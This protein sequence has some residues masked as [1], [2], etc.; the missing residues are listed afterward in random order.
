MKKR[1][2]IFVLATL[3]ALSIFAQSSEKPIDPKT[4]QVYKVQAAVVDG[5]TIPYFGLSEVTIFANGSFD[6][7]QLDYLT[8]CV[9]K[10]YPYAKITSETLAEMDVEMTKIRSK[11]DRK[12]YL[13]WAEDELKTA[14]AK[15]LKKL[16][17]SQGR[18][19]IK[20]VNRETGK[21]SYELVRELKG[22]F[23]AFMWQGVAKL[24][25]AN[26]KSEFDPKKEDAMIEYIVQRIERGELPVNHIARKSVVRPTTTASR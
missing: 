19:L 10:A 1:S 16:T 8:R 13:D 22:G 7:K 4:Q 14:F 23:S 26:L 15:D 6:T 12:K 11:K 25:G 17:Y 24:F 18:I 9:M 3:P 21:T 20:L 5:D 2:V